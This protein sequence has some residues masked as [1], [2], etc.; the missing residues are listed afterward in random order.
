MCT[1]VLNENKGDKIIGFICDCNVM[2][3]G[4]GEISPFHMSNSNFL[5]KKPQ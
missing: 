2:V 4:G 1:E 5:R 3:C